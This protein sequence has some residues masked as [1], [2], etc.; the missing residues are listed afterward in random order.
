MNYHVN[1]PRE[2]D[3]KRV[4]DMI[5]GAFEGG[6]NYWLGDGRVELVTPTYEE[7]GGKDEKIVWY[8]RETDN[9]FAREE[10]TITIDVPEDEL[11]TLD[12]TAVARGLQVMGDKYPDHY[13][14]LV[15]ENDDAATADVFLQCALFGELVYG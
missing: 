14:D 4:Q 11:R 7:L 9:V 10:F 15:G 13:N 1:V 3:A 12:R 8:G 6:S 2:I 5:V